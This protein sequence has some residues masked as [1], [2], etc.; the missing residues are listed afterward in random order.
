MTN[1]IDNKR[2]VLN[3]VR[4]IVHSPQHVR[5]FLAVERTEFYFRGDLLDVGWVRSL[6]HWIYQTA[7]H[8]AGN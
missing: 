4:F 7:S 3:I 8:A 6:K 5:F 1:K 2:A